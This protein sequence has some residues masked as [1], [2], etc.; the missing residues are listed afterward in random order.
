MAQRL[1]LVLLQT[2]Q[3]AL[4]KT[5]QLALLLQLVCRFEEGCQTGTARKTVVAFRLLGLLQE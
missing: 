5:L 1:P 4:L 2:L 3:L